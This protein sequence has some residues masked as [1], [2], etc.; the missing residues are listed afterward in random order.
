[1]KKLLIGFVAT[2]IMGAFLSSC[3][4]NCTCTETWIDDGKEESYTFM[5]FPS[6]YGLKNCREMQIKLKDQDTDVKCK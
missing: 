1:M 3:S 2:F 6:N 4:K 5:E